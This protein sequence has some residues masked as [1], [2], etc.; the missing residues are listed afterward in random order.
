MQSLLPKHYYCQYSTGD[1][2][3]P[4]QPVIFCMYNKTSEAVLLCA[5]LGV[6]RWSCTVC[7][8]RCRQ[9]ELYCVHC[10]VQ[11]GGA[12]QCYCYVHCQVQIGGAVQCTVL[13]LCAL[14]AVDKWS[15]TVCSARCR[16]AEQYCVLCQLQTGGAAQCYCCVH[17]QVQT[18]RAVQCYCRVHCQAKAIEKSQK[19]RLEC[20]CW[21]LVL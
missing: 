1:Y 12:V 9:V 13:L 10:Q 5:L 4:D 20:W 18:G 21:A 8:A 7:T 11:T 15:Y 16:Q 14:P 19:C 2:Q 6:D 3:L 17:C